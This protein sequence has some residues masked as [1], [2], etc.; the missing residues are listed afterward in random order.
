MKNIFLDGSFAEI[1]VK[2]TAHPGLRTAKI[3]Y[4]DDQPNSNGYGV[5]YEDFPDL[6]N[7]LI[8]TPVKIKFVGT[9]PSG[10]K[11]SI[12]IGHITQVSEAEVAGVHQLIVD[13]LLFADD[14]PDEIEYLDTAFAEGKAP[15]VSFEVTYH[16]SVLKNGIQWIKGLVAR[17]ATFVRSPAYGD[18]TALLALAADKNLSAE[19]FMTELSA[20]IVNNESQKTTKGGNNRMDKEL[21]EAL[22]KIATLEAELVTANEAVAAKSGEVVTLTSTNETLT[23]EI[24]TK[25]ATIAE[26]ES[27][28]VLAER[29]AALTEAGI[30]LELK[31]E[32]I[33]AMS[34]ED[35]AAYVEDLKAVAAAAKPDTKETKKLMASRTTRLPKFE[36]DGEKVETTDLVGKFRSISRSN[37]S[38]DTE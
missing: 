12:P 13:A 22:A 19:D 35:F 33:I 11:G 28:E 18:R 1:S 38:E 21:E 9:G 2:N 31:A 4:C 16:D 25:D 26:F 23:A 37:A 7:T 14:Y 3:I 36:T 5:E 30:E 34:D 20:L 27:K 15:G 10:H 8:G 32:R 24:E 17:A 29:R 6:E